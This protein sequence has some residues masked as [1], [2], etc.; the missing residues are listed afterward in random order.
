MAKTNPFVSIRAQVGDEKKSLEWY[1]QQ[2]KTL[3]RAS[4]QPNKLMQ[5][6]PELSTN[7]IPGA[8]YMFFYD[9]KYKD[10]LPY[11]DRFP[12]V[13][14]FRRANNG[15]YGINL[16]YLPYIMRFKLLGALHDRATD[17]KITEH[18]RVRI[19]WNMLQ[20]FVTIAPIQVCVKHYLHDH[21]QTKFLNI[22]YNDWITASLLPVEQFV[23]ATKQ[24]VWK[25]S[26]EAFNV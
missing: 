3:S 20:T 18:T 21:I 4:I 10:T 9:A 14:P 5:N 15:F 11:W 26:R 25:K 16:H 2:I 1:Q 23:G 19:N 6:V 22:K 8:M 12:L 17:S 7:I 13:I 24:E